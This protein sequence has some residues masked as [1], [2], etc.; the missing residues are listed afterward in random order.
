MITVKVYFVGHNKKTN[1]K[2]GWF[3]T[4]T[5]KTLEEINAWVDNVRS[6]YNADGYIGVFYRYDTDNEESI[7]GSRHIVLNRVEPFLITDGLTGDQIKEY[8]GRVI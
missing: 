3:E 7:K 8:V 2:L 4:I 6:M 1:D 5:K